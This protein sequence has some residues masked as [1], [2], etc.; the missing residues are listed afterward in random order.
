MSRSVFSSSSGATRKSIFPSFATSNGS[1]PS[2]SQA[3]LTRSGTGKRLRFQDDADTRDHGDFGKRRGNAS[4]GGIAQAM[5]PD[6]RLVNGRNQVT[7][8]SRVALQF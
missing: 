5:R 8:G 2:I 3:V 1:R 4:P 6:S 7:Q